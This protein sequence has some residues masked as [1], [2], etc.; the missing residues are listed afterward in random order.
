MGKS[1][2]KLSIQVQGVSISIDQRSTDEFISLTDMVA[3]HEEPAQVI[4]QWMR[5]YSTIE[6]L[7]TWEKLHNPHFELVDFDQLLAQAG[8]NT[9][10]L[11]VSR[12]KRETNAVGI[13]A[14]KGKG[15]G[16]YAHRDIAFEFGSWIS[17]TFRL[18]M[19]KEFQRLK[20][21]EA[22]QVG[23]RWDFARYLTKVNHHL[24]T[25][26][27]K[28][29]IIKKIR[30]NEKQLGYIYAREADMLNFAVFGI[31][32]KEWREA[33]PELAEKGNLRDFATIEELTVMANL[34]AINSQLIQAGASKESRLITL[35]EAAEYQMRVIRKNLGGAK[36]GLE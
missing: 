1:T 27:I 14:K 12:W 5:S 3:N 24:H 25:D 23:A 8:S 16:T 30:G 35:C 21:K 29:G 9:F 19:V 10:T 20:E 36:D 13:E 28:T 32:A 33:N 34:E 6:F 31:T 22:R 15:G 26:S 2:R 4:K 17:P 7:G 18:L 11:S